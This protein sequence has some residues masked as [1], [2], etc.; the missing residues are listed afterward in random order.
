MDPGGAPAFQALRQQ[1]SAELEQLRLQVEVM[2]VRVADAVRGA[3]VVLETGDHVLAEHIVGADDE[4]DAM[5]VSLTERCYDLIRR[6]S[7]VAADFRLVVSV[8]RIL[9][10]LERVG[11]LSL[12][13]VKAVEDHAVLA[14]HP[15]VLATLVRM[16]AVAEDSFAIASK[17]WASRTPAPAEVLAAREGVI[18]DDYSELTTRLLALRGED[19]ARVA[20]T[21]V[22]VGRSLERISDHAVVIGERLGYLLTGDRSHLASEVRGA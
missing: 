11:D 20:I 12:R 17:A 3:R 8:L 10:E 4:I 7:P 21:A 2:S 19:A 13:V 18:D 5:H 1:F 15:Q 9:E 22:L 14:R 6:E 16:A